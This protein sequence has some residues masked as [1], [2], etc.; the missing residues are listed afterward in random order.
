MPILTSVPASFSME[1]G[2]IPCHYPPPLYSVLMGL[3]EWAPSM[4]SLAL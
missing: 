1:W 4:G 3:R 2:P